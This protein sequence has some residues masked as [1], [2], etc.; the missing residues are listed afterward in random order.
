M[1]LELRPVK[2]GILN[3]TIIG[4]VDTS[5]TISFTKYYDKAVLFKCILE[6]QNF[7]SSTIKK[8][9]ERLNLKEDYKI[10]IFVIQEF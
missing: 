4:I 2:V 7:C 1:V 5:T 8:D 3:I 9:E 6:D 10:R